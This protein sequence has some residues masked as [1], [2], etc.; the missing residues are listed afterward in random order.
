LAANFEKSYSLPRGSSPAPSKVFII[1]PSPIGFLN[2]HVGDSLFLKD[3]PN[4][5]L[6]MAPV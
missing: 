2:H 6:L 3:E 1:L 4:P 5:L